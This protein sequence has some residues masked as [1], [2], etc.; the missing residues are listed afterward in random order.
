M[1]GQASTYLILH[2]I[3]SQ[4]CKKHVSFLNRY[5][6][7]QSLIISHL[8]VWS[9]SLFRNVICSSQYYAML[10]VCVCMYTKHNQVML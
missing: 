8:V 3:L 10:G 5:L 1:L 4:T 7:F 9:L 6:Y 2:R